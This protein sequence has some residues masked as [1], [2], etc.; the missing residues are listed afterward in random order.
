VFATITVTDGASVLHRR[1][2]VR[3]SDNLEDTDQDGHLNNSDAFPYDNKE[4]VDFDGDGVGDNADVDRDDDGVSKYFD[5]NDFDKS[6]G[7]F[8]TWQNGHNSLIELGLPRL[9][10]PGTALYD[11]DTIS[12]DAYDDG[13]D[14]IITMGPSNTKIS[15]VSVSSERQVEEQVIY[16]AEKGCSIRDIVKHPVQPY[17]IFAEYC[18]QDAN[19]TFIKKLG[20]KDLSIELHSSY[21]GKTSAHLFAKVFEKNQYSLFKNYSNLLFAYSDQAAEWE[22]LPTSSLSFPYRLRFT[23]ANPFIDWNQDGLD[24][25][26]GVTG[27]RL[28][29]GNGDFTFDSNNDELRFRTGSK[30]TFAWDNQNNLVQKYLSIGSETVTV[31]RGKQT[32]ANTVCDR[33]LNFYNPKPVMCEDSQLMDFNQDGLLDLVGLNTFWENNGDYRFTPRDQRSD[34]MSSPRLSKIE[35]SGDFDGDGVTDFVAVRTSKA[36]LY[37]WQAEPRVTPLGGILS[38]HE[39]LDEASNGLN[40]E[41]LIEPGLDADHFSVD[42]SLGTV[43]FNAPA[44]L[45]TKKPRYQ[46]WLMAKTDYGHT[47]KLLQVVVE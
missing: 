18:G 12:A 3:I 43:Q 1:I 32:D 14:E 21:R 38:W 46:C 8:P 6:I 24:D 22:R 44:T 34:S 26:V 4:W 30:N 47:R 45:N 23:P 29:D 31:V 41:Y 2:Q 36:K 19:K 42:G 11:W 16:K 40:V 10:I 39:S 13:K 27:A 25:F 9:H 37:F 28:N 35:L 7:Q 15:L 17:A 33:N 5:L 20:F